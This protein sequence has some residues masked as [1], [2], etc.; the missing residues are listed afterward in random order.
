[1]VLLMVVVLGSG[2]LLNAET[3]ELTV[4]ALLL[5]PGEVVVSASCCQKMKLK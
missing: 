5:P 2:V 3:G 1:V 4:L